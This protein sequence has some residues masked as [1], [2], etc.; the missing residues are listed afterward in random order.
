MTVLFGDQTNYFVAKNFCRKGDVH[1]E[2]K[3]YEEAEKL[4]HQAQVIIG[5]KY[6]E[7]HPII[8]G[9]N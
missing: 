9:F 8:M 7:V 3:E 5:E 6:S 1:M 4:Y 2:K